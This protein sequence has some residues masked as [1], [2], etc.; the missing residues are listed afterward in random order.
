M[1]HNYKFLPVSRKRIKALTLHQFRNNDFDHALEKVRYSREK[2]Q[3]RGDEDESGKV[4]MDSCRPNKH[5][6]HFLCPSCLG[7]RP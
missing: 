6:I 4:P 5:G 1:R 7:G 3:S 2:L